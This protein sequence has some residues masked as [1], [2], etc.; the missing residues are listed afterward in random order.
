MA[1]NRQLKPAQVLDLGI[2]DVMFEPA[3]FLEESLL[4]AA[5]GP[6]RRRHKVERPEIDR[7]AAW[8]ETVPQRCAPVSTR[9]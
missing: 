5:Q 1:Q 9:G 3:D 6:H 7:G 2:A 8:D 4:W